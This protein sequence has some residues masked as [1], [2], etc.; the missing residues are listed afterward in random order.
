[1]GLI[2][3]PAPDPALGPELSERHREAK[4]I[5]AAL[6]LRL[7]AILLDE[8]RFQLDRIRRQEVDSAAAG[9]G[10]PAE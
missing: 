8:G 3:V 6:S 1:L 7:A 5:T 4:G 2:V 10:A 9:P